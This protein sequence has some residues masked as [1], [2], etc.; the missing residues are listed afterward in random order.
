MYSLLQ[1]LILNWN[2]PKDLMHETI[3]RRR[4]RRR[5]SSS[6]SSSNKNNNN[7]NNNLLLEGID[8]VKV[9]LSLCL[10]ARVYPKVSGLAA[11]SENCKW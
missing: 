9:N 8:K 4:R 2:S 3:M 10:T 11:W 7:N 1:K 5:S 6:S